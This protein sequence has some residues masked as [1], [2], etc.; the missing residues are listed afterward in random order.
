[1]FSHL[2]SIPHPENIDRLGDLASIPV[3]RILSRDANGAEIEV[4]PG[5]SRLVIIMVIVA[6]LSHLILEE[7]TFGRHAFS[8]G[9]NVEASR[10]SGINVVR[11]KIMAFVFAGLLAGIVGVLLTSRLGGPPG[12]AVGYAVIAIACAMI[13]GASLSGGAGS[14][15]G[16]IIGSLLLSTLAMGLTMMNAN[17]VSLPLLLNGLVLLS[18]VYLDEKRN[19]K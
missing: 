19:R 9:S 3:F 11:V 2:N 10:L 12:G 18:S 13:G 6:A 17:A 4:F 1:M 7:T 14:V 5:I 16:T 15:G 8:V